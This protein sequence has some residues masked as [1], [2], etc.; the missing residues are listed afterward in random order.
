[1]HPGRLAG[2]AEARR[3][4]GWAV[5][6]QASR[7]TQRVDLVRTPFPCLASSVSCGG[8]RESGG[9]NLRI[10]VAPVHSGLPSGH[11]AIAYEFAPSYARFHRSLLEAT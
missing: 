10:L 7:S 2:R 11:L 1:M 9:E 6:L 8:D 3:T 4:A 5:T